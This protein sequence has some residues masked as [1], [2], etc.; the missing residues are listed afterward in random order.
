MIRHY[1]KFSAVLLFVVLVS[2]STRASH[3]S[4]RHSTREEAL[5][6]LAGFTALQPSRHWPNV[7]PVKFL[8]NLRMNADNPMGLYAGRGTN[9]CSYAALSY[10][11]LNHDP[12]GFAKFMLTLYEQGKATMGSVNFRPSHPVLKAAGTLKYKGKMDE[13]PADQMW[14]LITADHFKGYLNIFNRNYDQGDED[15]FWAVSNYAKFNRMV[16]KLFNYTT[17]SVGSD[18]L[19]PMTTGL[20]DYLVNRMDSGVVFLFVNNTRLAKKDH[21]AKKRL[22]SHFIVLQKIVAEGD[23]VTITYWDNGA[24]TLQQVSRKFLRKITFGVTYANPTSNHAE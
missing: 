9:F 4:S 16:R 3:D 13:R 15:R 24:R 1:I 14:L 19:R 20:T 12:L 6:Y 18:F 23:L 22:P 8:E 7:A 5:N 2:T 21:G 10:I 11:P 17:E